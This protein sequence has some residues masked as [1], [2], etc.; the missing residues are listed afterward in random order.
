MTRPIDNQNTAKPPV[1]LSDDQAELERERERAAE[2]LAK[3]LVERTFTERR[4]RQT[5]KGKGE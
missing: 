2:A 4:E 3:W 5:K 1:E